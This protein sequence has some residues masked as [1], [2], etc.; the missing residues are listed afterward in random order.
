M[1]CGCDGGEK[2]LYLA[3]SYQLSAISQQPVSHRFNPA[4]LNVSIVHQDE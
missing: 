1:S 4:R 2:M 3:V